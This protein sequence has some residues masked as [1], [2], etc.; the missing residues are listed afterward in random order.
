MW[1][2]S[3]K[4]HASCNKSHGMQFFLTRVFA[5]EGNSFDVSTSSFIC[6]IA[7]SYRFDIS[8]LSACS[9]SLLTLQLNGD[10]MTISTYAS[11]KYDGSS[12]TVIMDMS[13]GDVVNVVSKRSPSC[14][15]GYYTSMLSTTVYTT[16]TGQLIKVQPR[17]LSGG[18][19][20]YF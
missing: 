19:E 11:S 2:W 9:D 8:L 17:A 7:G 6:Q 1:R 14:L 16:F 12:N 13:V 3:V 10:M 18:F 4:N 5:N 15:Y 20:L